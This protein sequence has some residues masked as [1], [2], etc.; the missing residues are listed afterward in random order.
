MDVSMTERNGNLMANELAKP[1]TAAQLNPDIEPDGDL[2]SIVGANLRRLRVRRG[3]SLERLA[4]A[5]GVS[6][7][8]LGQIELARSTPTI[9]VLWKVART[10]NVSFS[11]LISD[12]DEGASAVLLE[13]VHAKTLTSADGAFRSR[14]L[15]PMH[16]P[17]KV[18]FYELRLSV[19]GVELA[20][21][22]PPG[23]TENLAVASGELEL[24][25]GDRAFRLGEG[26]AIH[27]VADVPHEYRNAGRVES[28]MYLV[29]T[30]A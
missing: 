14:A 17:R 29:M 8:M 13:R 10:L 11:A 6:R 12:H 15:S 28:V 1:V 16:E 19:A 7:A 26:D 4:R 20:E 21:P 5:S 27:F 22:H 30:Y 23:T 2:T 3:L 25:V 9:K 24:R 18:E